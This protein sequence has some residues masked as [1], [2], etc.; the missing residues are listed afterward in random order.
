M[1]SD[2][3]DDVEISTGEFPPWLKV[4]TGI[5]FSFKLNDPK[6]EPR[7]HKDQNFNRDQWIWD[8]EIIDIDPKDAFGEENKNGYPLYEKGK[9]YSLALAKRAMQR[10]K[11]LWV[12]ADFK[13]E[14]FTMKRTGSGFNTDY[15]FNL[16][17]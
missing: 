12:E 8:V 2:F 7:Y 11:A 17:E 14:K 1:K 16:I 15:I 13:V 9:V 4:Q 5:T 10:F 3:W 6:K